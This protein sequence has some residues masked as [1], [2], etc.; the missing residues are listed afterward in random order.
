MKQ[1]FKMM[2]ASM[3]GFFITFLIICVLVI[4]IIASVASS[5]K[6]EEVV[7]ATNSILYIDLE[8]TITDRSSKNPFESMNFT[9]F[10]AEKQIGLDD[11]LKNLVKAKN[12]PNIKGIFLDLSSI[13][14]GIATVE[15][16]RNAL[17]DFKSSKKFI[18]CYS[19]VFSQSS[20]YLASAAD[21][22][23]LNP[24]GGMELKGLS[25]EVMFFKGALEKLDLEPQIIR[26]GQ[27]K[28][29]IEP[30]VL[31]KMSE[32]NRRQTM[33]YLGSIWDHILNGIS[34]SRKVSV[35]E[36]NRMAD[37]MLIQTAE[38]AVTYKLVDKA[39]Y[40]DEVLSLLKKK[41][42]VSEKDK[43]KFVS[44]K[45]YIDSPDKKRTISENKI[46]VIF[47]SGS[48]DSGEGDEGTIGS[49]RIS[50][51]IRDARMDNSVKAIVLRVNSPGG[52]ALASD[53]I[54]R[55][56]VLA[57]KAK[58]VIASMGDV[59]ASGGY[60]IS[61][62]ADTI[63]ASPNTITGSIGVFGV[64][65]NSQR[66][67]KEKL[68]ITIDTV[69]TN[70]HADIGS[71]FRPLTASEKEVIQKS[72]EHIYDVFVSRVAEGRELSKVQVDSIGQGRVWSGTDA[73]EIGLVD[74]LGGLDKAIEIAAAK[75]KLKNYRVLS[76][77]KQKE[78]L[79]HLLSEFSDDVETRIIKRNLGSGY[80]YYNHLQQVIKSDGIQARMPYEVEIY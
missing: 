24:Q 14:A 10:M 2:L 29:A 18:I 74:V 61:C 5:A 39:L 80:K 31:E 47:A 20:Y 27:F 1:F 59:A 35:Q 66:L 15:E 22:I 19:E 28:S 13:N 41:T 37:Q 70:R 53:V 72:V 50:K 62:A 51:A 6:D 21:K 3:L 17:L 34:K 44:I 38:D 57:R 76:L 9:S 26:H 30:L 56:V 7:V 69:K 8:E 25:A 67:L 23:Y 64:L 75:A 43:I 40:K 16:I 63:V 49:E 4:V 11:I 60:Y 58:P 48:I 71:P 52:S 32:P 55:E 54:W 68:G 45:K 12:D 73:K 65:I 79:E 46:A 33:T 77:P 78:P 42:G 36:L